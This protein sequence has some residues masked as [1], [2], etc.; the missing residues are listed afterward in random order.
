M[1]INSIDVYIACFT[2]YNNCIEVRRKLSWMSTAA[3][4]AAGI[5]YYLDQNICFDNLTQYIKPLILNG[6]YIF[7][8]LIYLTE[9]WNQQSIRKKTNQ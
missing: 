9:V 3:F 5:S 4:K 7:L 1:A 8:V 6:R 2:E